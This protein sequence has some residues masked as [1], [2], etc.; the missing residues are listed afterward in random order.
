MQDPDI[1]ISFRAMNAASESL[2]PHEAEQPK[3]ENRSRC[4]FFWGPSSIVEPH[5]TIWPQT[6]QEWPYHVHRKLPSWFQRICLAAG[7]I[8]CFF[9]NVL[10]SSRGYYSAAFIDG[11]NDVDVL[12]CG[13]DKEVWGGPNTQC[14]SNATECLKNFD[15]EQIYRFKCPADCVREGWTFQPM[16][17]GDHIAMREFFVVGGENI[18]RADSFPCAAA[19]HRGLVSKSRGGCAVIKFRGSQRSFPAEKGQY[20]QQSIPFDAEFPQSYS[21]EETHTL[22]HCYDFRWLQAFMN[23]LFV[24]V[25]G[26]L[27]ESPLVFLLIQTTIGFWTVFLASNPVLAGGNPEKN[28]EVVSFGFRRFLPCMLGVLAIYFIACKRALGHGGKMRAYL[29]RSLLWGGAFF[30]GIC[31]NYVFG[32]IP[33]DR[34]TFSDLNSQMGAW[35]AL[36]IIVGCVLAIAIGQAYVIWRLGKFWPYLL[37]YLAAILSLAILACW[38]RQTLRIHHYILAL[39]LLPGTNFQT[40]PS[41]VYNGLLVGLYVAGV[42]RWGFDSILQTYEQ[43]ARGGPPEGT[44]H[45]AFLEPIINGT[46]G[47]IIQDYILQWADLSQSGADRR[48]DGFSLII[49]DVERYRGPATSFNLTNWAVNMFSQPI[50]TK[51]YVRLALATLKDDEETGAFTRAATALLDV[52]NWTMPLP[53]TT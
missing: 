31:E 35:T 7:V 52:G 22:E 32:A 27:V 23:F 13:I 29:T 41:L 38:P 20:D 25:F 43:L 44:G 18:Y 10:I 21:F 34:L 2:L 17:V 9:S 48:F 11:E 40:T 28:A 5:L 36:I 14:G 6:V 42:S 47:D 24:L 1:S 16:P 12:K 49:N 37:S 4:S 39:V 19:V 51:Y 33:I 53:G 3:Q 30:C 26:Y 46:V 45:P 50:P 8:L 15:E